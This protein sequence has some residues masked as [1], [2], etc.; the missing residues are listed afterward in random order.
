[1]IPKTYRI[2]NGC[3]DCKNCFQEHIH[4][5]CSY[6]CAIDGKI[7]NDPTSG[8]DYL[9]DNDLEQFHKYIKEKESLKVKPFGKCDEWEMEEEYADSERRKR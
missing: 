3:H 2:E 7:P 1:M 9:T 4:D 6:Y 5:S 8:I